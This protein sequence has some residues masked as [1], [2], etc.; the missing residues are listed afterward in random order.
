MSST[1]LFVFEGIKTEE[2]II[3]SLTQ[4]FV[5]QNSNVTCAFC[6]D[7]YQ[8][9]TK[10]CNDPNLDTFSI[11]K[12]RNQN[13]TK[14]ADYKRSDFAEIYLFFDYDGHAPN[15][16]DAAIKDLVTFFNEETEAGKVYI[17][18]P[19]VEALI[20]NSSSINF[21]SLKVSGKININ[22]KGIVV[23]DG[24]D[25]LK[26]FSRLSKQDWNKLIEIHL[27][28]MNSIVNGTYV[29]PTIL[30]TQLDVFN[31]QFAKFINIDST[32]AVLSGFPIFISDYYGIGKIP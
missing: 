30:I 29:L 1:I 17:S 22:Y 8:L 11:L 15:A 26:H 28:K 9:Y 2:K 7:V 10:L 23:A 21:E 32:V 5:N 16:S 25:H 14:L 4:Y 18:Y 27:K 24:A 13:K 3:N 19:M 6:S 12:N 31:N 20:H